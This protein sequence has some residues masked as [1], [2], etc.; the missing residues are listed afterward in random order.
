MAV[1]EPLPD[2]RFGAVVPVAAWV[3]W[4]PVVLAS[5]PGCLSRPRSSTRCRGPRGRAPRRRRVTLPPTTRRGCGADVPARRTA[6]SRSTGCWEIGA[7]PWGPRSVGVAP[8]WTGILWLLLGVPPGRPVNP[9]E[10]QEPLVLPW[11]CPN[12]GCNPGAGAGSAAVLVPGLVLRG[13]CAWPPSS[14]PPSS[15]QPEKSSPLR[16]AATDLGRCLGPRR[17]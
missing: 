4:V 3:L 13:S 16:A 2:D 6:R 11:L 10:T 5:C 15:C 12:P 17:G 1:D 9:C 8:R 7:G 14:P